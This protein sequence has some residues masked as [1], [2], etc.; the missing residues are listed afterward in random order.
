MFVLARWCGFAMNATM[1]RSK[2]GVL[3]V[4]V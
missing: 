3:S 1:V 4:V 2:V